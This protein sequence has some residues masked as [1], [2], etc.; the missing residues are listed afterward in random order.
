MFPRRIA[1]R[2]LLLLVAVALML[3]CFLASNPGDCCNNL[4]PCRSTEPCVLLECIRSKCQVASEQP[5]GCCTSDGACSDA[6]PCTE[7]RCDPGS[8]MCTFIPIPECCVTGA[9]DE[10]QDGDRCT[11]D[12]CDFETPFLAEASPD[13]Y[14][15]AHTPVTN[16]CRTEADC[17]CPVGGER[18]CV[19]G[20]CLPKL[21]DGTQCAV[22]ADC[23][24]SD[25]LSIDF[26]RY[27]SRC[28]SNFGC[29]AGQ[30]VLSRRSGCCTTDFDCAPKC[31]DGECGE[32]ALDFVPTCEEVACDEF[33]RLTGDTFVGKCKHVQADTLPFLLDGC[34]TQSDC[35]DGIDGTVDSCGST[36]SGLCD[37]ARYCQHTIQFGESLRACATPCVEGQGGAFCEQYSCEDGDPCTVD[38]CLS[39]D[40]FASVHYASGTEFIDVDFSSAPPEIDRAWLGVCA[41]DPIPNCCASD[42]DCECGIGA[43]PMCTD[44]RCHC[45]PLTGCASDADCDDRDPCTSDLCKSNQCSHEAVGQCCT[46]HAQCSDGNTFSDDYCKPDAL[47]CEHVTFTSE[48][49]GDAECG[50]G[51]RCLAFR[52]VRHGVQDDAV[53]EDD[54][55]CV[56]RFG[57]CLDEHFSAACVQNRCTVRAAARCCDSNL[58]LLLVEAALKS[59]LDG[60]LQGLANDWRAEGVCAAVFYLTDATTPQ[61]VKD[62]LTAYLEYNQSIQLATGLDGIVIVGN[63]PPY[64]VQV[65]GEDAR[66]STDHVYMAPAGP[67]EPTSGPSVRWSGPLLES[68]VASDR[69]PLIAGRLTV[70]TALGDRATVLL[71]Y[72]GKLH[73]YRY[74]GKREYPANGK[75]VLVSPYHPAYW[76]QHA[77]GLASLFGDGLPAGLD[78]FCADVPQSGGVEFRF[79]PSAT[80][81]D[82]FDLLAR[83]YSWLT[84]ESH[85]AED[86]W[87]AWAGKVFAH[88][89]SNPRLVGQHFFWHANCESGRVMT[90]QPD[91]TWQVAY[92]MFVA[93]ELFMSS[94]YGIAAVAR[95][96]TGTDFG[97]DTGVF[98]AALRD[99]ASVGEAL[100]QKYEAT[101]GSWRSGARCTG[102]EDYEKTGYTMMLF[103]DPFVSPQLGGE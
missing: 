44:S 81:R 83:P 64:P 17:S 34:F 15:C 49:V 102:W 43:E 99:G 35:D 13:A 6:N 36:S 62:R 56:R 73:H 100:R 55:D 93:R 72:L 8:R 95:G 90:Y 63:I 4:A 91:G 29:V 79:G 94:E 22:D 80:P 41:N 28:V 45:V 50:A 86:N 3:P 77:Q 40:E 26:D 59:K 12:S 14:R 66:G 92:D 88:D 31:Q 20:W 2:P 19:E 51:R 67:W 89:I 69:V 46:S 18:T 74:G 71:R 58:R 65:L 82:Y 32:Y 48:C 1:A 103:G 11:Y 37:Q 52:C 16:C 98:Y 10:C 27:Q 97:C 61:R 7:D 23:Y 53:C 38:Q 96:S 24:D 60:A 70:P 9:P 57:P 47:T 68:G 21:A 39:T 54:L 5:T 33:G 87:L 75:A 76:L 78:F 85:G 84:V 25:E 101:A 42:A 30:C